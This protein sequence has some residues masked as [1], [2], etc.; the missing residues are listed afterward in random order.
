MIRTS[1]TSDFAI[2]FQQFENFRKKAI[3]AQNFKQI[4]GVLAHEAGRARCWKSTPLLV[5]V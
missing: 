3:L 1:A 5:K 2:G 4:P